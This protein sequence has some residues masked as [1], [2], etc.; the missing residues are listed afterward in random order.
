MRLS[1]DGRQPSRRD[2]KLQLDFRHAVD[3]RCNEEARSPL[4]RIARWT[5]C[6]D[7]PVADLAQDVYCH[8]LP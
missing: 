1:R 8:R 7:R 3:L 4:R 6:F 2:G 5:L